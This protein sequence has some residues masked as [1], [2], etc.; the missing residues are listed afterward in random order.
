MASRL[1]DPTETLLPSASLTRRFLAL[2]CAVVALLGVTSVPAQAADPQL[3]LENLS[4]S[5]L[6]AKLSDGS[7]TSVQLTRAY[8]NRIAALN[9]RGPGLNAI[10]ILNSNALTEAKASDDRRAAGNAGPL[11][12]LPVIVKDNVD[13]AGMPTTAGSIAL[14]SNIPATDSPA[15]ARLRANGAILLAKANLSEYA[16]FFS[17]GTNPS[18]YSSLGGQVLNATDASST[19][20]GS[21]SGSGVAASTGLAALTIGSETS[22]SIISPSAA[23]GDVGLRPTIGLVPR[24][25]VVPISATQDTLGPIVRNVKDAAMELQAIAGKD[26]EDAA[27]ASAPDTVPDY[28][29]GLKTDA[30]DGKRIGVV[31]STDP[32]YLQAIDDLRAAGAV[33]V[34]TT[35]PTAPFTAAGPYSIL[36]YEFKRDL[37]A[38][39]ARVAAKGGRTQ[40]A[41]ITDV[42]AYNRAH[43]VEG[44]KFGQGQIINSEAIDPNATASNGKTNAQNN[45]TNVTNSVTTARNSINTALNLTDSDASNDLDALFTPSG[46]TTG[47]GAR[48]QW[49][50]ITVPAGVST[51]SRN[52]IGIAFQGT[53]Y[54]EA[55]L[56]AFAYAYEQRTKARTGPARN[57]PSIERCADVAEPKPFAERSCMPS[58]EEILASIGGRAPSLNFSLES[59]TAADLQTKLRGRS[60]SSVD[61]TKGYL[62]RIAAVNNAGP[63]INAVRSLNPEA[64]DE[65]ADSDDY[66]RTHATPRPLEGLPIL[67]K[68]NLDV[69]GL[70][71]AGGSIA[72]QN[73]IPK[74]DSTVVD[75]LKAAGAVIVGKTNMT[76]FDN[77][78]ASTVTSGGLLQSYMPAGYSSLGGYT[79]D[80]YD[81]DLIQGGGGSGGGTAN[82][83]V[84][85]GGGSAG[86]ASAAAAGLAAMTVGTET[87][88]SI[89][90]PSSANSVVGMR[91][92]YGT[93]SRTGMLPAAKSQ[94]TPGTIGKTVTDVA[95]GLQAL[96]GRDADDSATS[97]TS[98]ATPN[99]L[100]GLTTNALSGK[101]IGVTSSTNANYLAAQTALTNA[102][103][104][105]VTITAPAQPTTASVFPYE[106]K[107]DLNAY[108]A[109]SGVSTDVGSL[110]DVISYNN[111]HER[112][113]LKYNQG[114]LTAAQSQ[115]T[116]SGSSD[117]STYNSNVTAGRTQAQTN[118]NTALSGPDGVAG[119][120]DDVSALVLPEDSRTQDTTYTAGARAG[121]PQISVPAGYNEPTSETTSTTHDPVAVTF[122]GGANTDAALLGYAY[123]YEQASVSVNVGAS[124]D[125]LARKVPSAINPATWHCAPD[126]VFAPRSCPPGDFLAAAD[127]PSTPAS[128]PGTASGTPSGTT[129]GSGGSGGGSS[130]TSP[131]S[132]AD[133][134]VLPVPSVRAPVISRKLRLS[135]ARSHSVAV[136]IKCGVS[137]GTKCKGR[138]RIAYGRKT[139]GSRAFSIKA[140]K[141]T[142]VRVRLTAS[143]YRLLLR[144]KSLKSKITLT[145]KGAD[146]NTRTSALR[147]TLKPKK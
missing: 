59:A 30:L 1:T 119:T 80:P 71:T 18:G 39:L 135:V 66:R 36:T 56:L 134:A 89:V 93:V 16:N 51:T 113:G 67:V 97:G 123:A 139:L 62:A 46:T 118:V 85:G 12:G 74:R 42:V 95:L 94:D 107:R 47:T 106:F 6:E 108:L 141:A 40:S 4:A 48:A 54:T 116:S 25:G 140:N 70:P 132:P 17:S 91:P 43:P 88:G 57:N 23:N 84:V 110:R 14:E 15:V 121:Y 10:R 33:T 38:Y 11:E 101:R 127:T 122:L 120:T 83:S 79:L 68:D 126:S 98:T 31:A 52:P 146:A 49:P 19:P 81:T 45:D 2:A 124:S 27:T 22:G 24:T 8:I 72:L 102:G 64:L 61:L 77:L 26:P 44:T 114:Q 55:K 37:N 112:E 104:T 3:D 82:T 96:V 87:N 137:S 7:L 92:S 147:V 86:S 29:A 111:S 5:D 65:A 100:A 76:E 58:G 75:K 142:T 117:T 32:T 103:A 144:R 20:S 9:K 13:V 115:D 133:T 128:A 138:L 136:R 69:A 63:A 50:Q 35:L 53:G 129:G 78:M 125:P 130:P 105:L 41:S 60:L 99:Y 143:A 28:T 73:T 109:S 34:S 145:T 90:F 131:S 21:S